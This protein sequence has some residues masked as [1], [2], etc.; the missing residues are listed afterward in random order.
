MGK[1]EEEGPYHVSLKN[2]RMYVHRFFPLV[3]EFEA[4]SGS[5]GESLA[6]D[7]QCMIR[8]DSRSAYYFLGQS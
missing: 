4:M 3:S 8:Y 1:G 2:G 6:S 7:S 5:L